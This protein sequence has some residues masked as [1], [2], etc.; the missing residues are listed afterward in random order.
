MPIFKPINYCKP[1]SLHMQFYKIILFPHEKKIRI[2]CVRDFPE[3]KHVEI[4]PT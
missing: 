1:A 3:K 2:Y 4:V